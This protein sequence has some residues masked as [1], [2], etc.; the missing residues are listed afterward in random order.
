[1][2]FIAQSTATKLKNHLGLPKALILLTILVVMHWQ[3]SQNLHA[4]EPTKE[5]SSLYNFN[6]ELKRYPKKLWPIVQQ[7]K[8]GRSSENLNTSV[9][10]IDQLLRGNSR[11]LHDELYELKA[12]ALEQL[13]KKDLA[14]RSYQKS[15]EH[16]S[17][18]P[19]ALYRHALI[20]VSIN[21]CQRAIPELR[22][23]L[24]SSKTHESE[25]NYLIGICQLGT[26]REKAIGL[27]EKSLGQDQSFKPT[28]AKLFEIYS[29]QYEKD[30]AAGMPSAEL[31]Q[32]ML[33]LS[34][35]LIKQNPDENLKYK[36]TFIRLVSKNKDP[37]IDRGQFKLAKDYARQMV[38]K[39]NFQS[40][41]N[42]L[43][44]FDLLIK[45]RSISIAQKLIENAERKNPKLAESLV[46][47]KKQIAIETIR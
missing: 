43:I 7:L 38:I 36:Q 14:L 8:K 45:M 20:L 32:K 34:E 5:I 1:M 3:S 2:I 11:G 4:L 29:E 15:L 26:D 40:P 24:W 35:Q 9:R 46:G 30:Q 27:L 10:T 13:G 21:S 39:D 33:S 17:D 28:T 6:P 31:G 19:V 25:I 44:Y 16:R 18:N 22:E 47:A 12:F 37:F 42:V 41:E 23:L